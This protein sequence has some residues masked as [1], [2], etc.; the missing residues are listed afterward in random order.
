MK[1][2]VLTL[3]MFMFALSFNLMAT[4][5]VTTT[6]SDVKMEAFDLVKHTTSTSVFGKI[7]NWFNTKITKAKTWVAKKLINFDMQD[8]SSVIKW[9]L[10]AFLGAVALSVLGVFVPVV[11]YIGWLLGLASAVLFWYWVYLKFIA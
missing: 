7:K 8:P 6:S 1:L 9:C 10:I 5:P 2:K 3:M 11:G 4:N